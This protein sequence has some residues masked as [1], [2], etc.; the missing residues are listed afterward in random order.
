VNLLSVTLQWS[1]GCYSVVRRLLHKR[2]GW[3]TYLLGSARILWD[4]CLVS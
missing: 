1:S 2:T 4:R 3:C